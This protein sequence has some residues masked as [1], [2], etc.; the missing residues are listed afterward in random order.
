M[1]TAEV[2]VALPVL[3][4]IAL[5]GAGVVGAVGDELRCRDAARL[6]AR[7][8]ARGEPSDVV[9]SIAAQAAPTGARIDI[10]SG[11][12]V[13]SVAVSVVVRVPGPWAGKG[14][15]T[16]VSARA[17]AVAEPGVGVAAVRR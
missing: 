17:V 9:R 5:L 4:L 2:A 16:T 14:P 8:A 1:A 11:D 15:H 7:A 13:V 12:G 3:V 6:A 10:G